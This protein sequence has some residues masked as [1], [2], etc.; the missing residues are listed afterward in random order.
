MTLHAHTGLSTL[1]REIY[2]KRCL[3]TYALPMLFHLA[4]FIRFMVEGNMS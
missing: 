2:N 3:K 4:A 1:Q